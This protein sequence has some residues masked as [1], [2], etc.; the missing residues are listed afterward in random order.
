VGVNPWAELTALKICDN[1]GFCPSYA[2]IK[3]L[4]YAKTQNYDVINMSL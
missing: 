2:V 1:K 3:A 4:T